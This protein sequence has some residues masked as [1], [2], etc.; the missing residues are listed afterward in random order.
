MTDE[1][2]YNEMVLTKVQCFMIFKHFSTHN[3]AHIIFIY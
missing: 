2:K 3:K 1:I